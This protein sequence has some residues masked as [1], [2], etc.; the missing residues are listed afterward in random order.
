MIRP[1]PKRGLRTLCRQQVALELEKTATGNTGVVG[2]V[3]YV[4]QQ[5]SVV[6][7]DLDCSKMAGSEYPEL[8]FSLFCQKL[9]GAI[10]P[11]G[12]Y[13]KLYIHVWNFFEPS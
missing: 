9:E 4:V 1:S 10:P 11:R 13:R 2:M 8:A 5:Q 12:R 7:N 6:L 3:G